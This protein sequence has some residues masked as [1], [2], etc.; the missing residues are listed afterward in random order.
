MTTTTYAIR[1]TRRSDGQV[2]DIET[3]DDEGELGSYFAYT[4]G[5]VSRWVEATDREGLEAA[6]KR[7]NADPSWDYTVELV[8]PTYTPVEPL[9]EPLPTEP[10]YY[11]ADGFQDQPDHSFLYRLNSVGEW[12]AYLNGNAYRRTPEEMTD[13]AGTNLVRLT[14]N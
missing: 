10:G 8:E 1:A 9:P 5:G 11:V 14:A 13:K 6:V 7:T 12:F 3:R 4:I 2:A